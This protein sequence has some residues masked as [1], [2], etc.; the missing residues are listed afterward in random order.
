[1]E[2]SQIMATEFLNKRQEGRKPKKKQKSPKIP[3]GRSSILPSAR[4]QTLPPEVLLKILSFLDASS[5]Y[6]IGYVNKKLHELAN[7]NALWYRL[8]IRECT[9]QKLKT[10][11]GDEVADRLTIA[12][13]QEKPKGHWK[14]LL[15]KKMVGFNQSRWISQLKA[16]SPYTGLPKQTVH[17]L[18]S[19]GVTWELTVTNQDGHQ[20]TFKHSHTFFSECSLNL[21]WIGLG[22]LEYLGIKSM[23]LHSVVPLALDRGVASCRPAWRSLIFEVNMAKFNW[24]FF[25]S[26]VLVRARHC[27]SFP[28]LVMGIWRDNDEVVFFKA[29][30]HLHKLVEKCLL[31][32]IS[33]P[34][35]MPEHKPLFDDVDPEYGLHGYKVYIELHDMTKL[36]MSGQF[37]GLFCRREAVTKEF[38]VLQAISRDKRSQ[39]TAFADKFSLKWRSEGLE[40]SVEHCCV[41]S[42]TVLDESQTPFWCVSSPVPIMLSKGVDSRDYDYRGESYVIRYHGSEGRISLD[43][44]WMEELGQYFLVMFHIHLPVVKIN[45]YFGRSY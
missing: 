18:R 31:G 33:V 38:V 36:I 8:Y 6:S 30:L 11:L 22:A 7:N 37:S 17:V 24:R 40:G 32:S 35:S 19:L 34:Y 13:I 28:G 42:V 15:F 1:M 3:R 21:T 26:C 14:R 12:T 5:L 20:R 2:Q 39:H 27:I 9:K 44:V 45:R 4:L 23:Q 25:G 41:M 10:K 29:N 16:V 43:L